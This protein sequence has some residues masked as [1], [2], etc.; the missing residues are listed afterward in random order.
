MCSEGVSKNA[1]SILEE[2]SAGLKL[3]EDTSHSSNL[4]FGCGSL[5][6]LLRNFVRHAEI[7]DISAKRAKNVHKTQ[8]ANTTKVHMLNEEYED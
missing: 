2:T 3:E 7:I 8:V 4:D 5:H 1:E 6:D